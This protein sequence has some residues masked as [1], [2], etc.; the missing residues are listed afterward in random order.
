MGLW[1]SGA[2]GQA[3]PADVAWAVNIAVGGAWGRAGGAIDDSISPQRM[4][5]DYVRVCRPVGGD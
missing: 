4:L 2:A 3:G 5:V 1:P